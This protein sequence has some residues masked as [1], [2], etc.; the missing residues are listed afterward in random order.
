MS[1]DSQDSEPGRR[2]RILAL[3]GGGVKG[4]YTAS[5]LHTLEEL[6]GKSVGDHFDLITGTSTGGIIAVA[7]GLGVPLKDVLDLYV[8]KGPAIFPPPPSGRL[9]WLSDWRRRLWNPK[10]DQRILHDAVHDVL[11]E[12]TLGESKNRLVIPSFNAQSGDIQLFKTPHHPD[13]RMDCRLPASTVAMATSAAPTYLSAHQDHD[14]R[15]SIDGGV[16][17]NCP[18]MVGLVEGIAKLGWPREKIDILSVGTTSAPFHIAESKQNGGLL[19]WGTGIVEIFQEA[20]GK[21]MLGLARAL[22]G[23]KLTRIDEVTSPNRFVLDGAD[24]VGNLKALGENS[25]RQNLSKVE[26]HFFSNPADRYMPIAPLPI[27]SSKPV[28]AATA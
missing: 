21:G 9:A 26:K 4:A 1:S 20:Q 17:A 24:E 5:V 2:F 18:V 14:G 8:E 19:N 12:Q 11:G 28:G 25:A 6:T 23:E 16:W 10:H 3:D 13:Y 27:K 15:V 22:V 7:I